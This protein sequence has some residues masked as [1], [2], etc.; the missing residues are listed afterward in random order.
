VSE[1][2]RWSRINLGGSMKRLTGSA[3][4]GFLLNLIGMRNSAV[5]DMPES[6]VASL[7]RMRSGMA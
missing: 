2:I 4:S 3:P 5:E 7:V 6:K 1:Q